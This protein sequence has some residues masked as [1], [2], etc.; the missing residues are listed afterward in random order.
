MIV[1]P[2]L[3]TT[4]TT[5]PTGRRRRHSGTG[6]RKRVSQPSVASTPGISP[7]RSGIRVRKGWTLFF[8]GTSGIIRPI[9]HRERPGQQYH[10]HPLPRRVF[11]YIFISS[12]KRS[13][14]IFTNRLCLP[15]PLI[16]SPFA[17]GV[18]FRPTKRHVWY[19]WITCGTYGST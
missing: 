2:P 11:R 16:R 8:A 14:I 15:V 3:R 9:E 4:R 17:P 7:R 19:T 6:L 12:S 13:T 10:Q 1:F 5:T 18:P